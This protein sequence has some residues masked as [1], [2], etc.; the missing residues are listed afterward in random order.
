MKKI[1]LILLTILL[2]F[3]LSFSQTDSEINSLLNAISKTE[4]SKEIIKTEKIFVAGIFPNVYSLLYIPGNKRLELFLQ[5][6]YFLF[7]FL[8]LFIGIKG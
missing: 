6:I 4:N 2:N 7:L 3:N 5:Q 1:G 8:I